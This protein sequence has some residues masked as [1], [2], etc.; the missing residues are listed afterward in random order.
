[1]FIGSISTDDDVHTKIINTKAGPATSRYY[2]T[3]T[4]QFNEYSNA[5]QLTQDEMHTHKETRINLTADVLTA[6]RLIVQ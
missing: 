3:R 1:M 2:L 4:Q 5:A 6:T